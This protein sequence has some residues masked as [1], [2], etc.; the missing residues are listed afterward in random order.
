MAATAPCGPHPKPPD[1][2]FVPRS[3]FLPG[4]VFPR[5]STRLWHGVGRAGAFAWLGASR[6]GFSSCTA[7]RGLCC[8]HGAARV[9]C[10]A[11]PKPQAPPAAPVPLYQVFSQDLAA[12]DPMP[13]CDVEWAGPDCSPSLDWGARRGSS[14]WSRA[15]SALSVGKPAPAC[16]L[17][18]ESRLLQPFC[19]PQ[20]FSQQ[21]WGLVSSM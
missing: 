3:S 12:L 14:R 9:S 6:R 16:S 18:V 4:P 7:I 17:R 20:L 8:F 1:L 21:P 15:C 11:P 13:S 2:L 19:L 5:S 10:T